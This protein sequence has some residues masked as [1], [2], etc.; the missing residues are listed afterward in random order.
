MQTQPS[1]NPIY[2]GAVDCF[3]KVVAKEKVRK[4]YNI[5]NQSFLLDTELND[6]KGM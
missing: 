1:K 2:S 6:N 3:K 5:Y 4:V